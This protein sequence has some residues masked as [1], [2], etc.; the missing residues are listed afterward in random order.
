MKVNSRQTIKEVKSII[1]DTLLDNNEEV[2]L[3]F[4][5]KAGRPVFDN[6]SLE[7]LDNFG[8]K[9]MTLKFN[10]AAFDMRIIHH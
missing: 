4:D 8:D 10:F 6:T 2:T 1:I 9:T 3:V 5:I 7:F